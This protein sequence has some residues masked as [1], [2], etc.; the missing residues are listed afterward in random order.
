MLDS[1]ESVANINKS[2]MTNNNES[3]SWTNIG[4]NNYSYCVLGIDNYDFVLGIS[5]NHV[6]GIKEQV[7]RLYESRFPMK[8]LLCNDMLTNM[9]KV[10][11]C[12][13]STKRL[14]V[15]SSCLMSDNIS[16]IWC[17]CFLVCFSFFPRTCLDESCYGDKYS[18]R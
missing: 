17:I 16:I 13:C 11:S 4:I 14:F 8:K 5:C 15:N 6:L 18:K 1:W 9:N 3:R 12:I 10:I 7:H 2:G